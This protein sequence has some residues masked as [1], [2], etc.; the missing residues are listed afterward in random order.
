[1]AAGSVD[2]AVFIAAGIFQI[3]FASLL[4]PLAVI[5]FDLN[6]GRSHIPGRPGQHYCSSGGGDPGVFA[7]LS[8]PG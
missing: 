3:T 5:A 6:P 7:F 2:M 4:L 8:T 1:M